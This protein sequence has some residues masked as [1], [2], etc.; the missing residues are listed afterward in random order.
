VISYQLQQQQRQAKRALTSI[1][2]RSS[3]KL[4]CCPLA[5]ALPCER[6]DAVKILNQN[7]QGS[8]AHLLCGINWSSFADAL[9]AEHT[10]FTVA[11]LCSHLLPLS[12]FADSADQADSECRETQ[13]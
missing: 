11:P 13:H 12:G 5:C 4:L 2:S 8:W 9:A 3:D 6:S 7:G 1:T 10:F